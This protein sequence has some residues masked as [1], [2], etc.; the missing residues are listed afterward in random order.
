[1]AAAKI[2]GVEI[3]KEGSSVSTDA[4]VSEMQATLRWMCGWANAG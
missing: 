1:M 3:L 2:F 4:A